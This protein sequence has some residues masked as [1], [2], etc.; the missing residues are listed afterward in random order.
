MAWTDELRGRVVGLDTAPLIYHVEEKVPYLAAVDPFF[1]ALTAGEF[2]VVTSVLTLSEAL[3]QPVRHN[4]TPLAAIYRSILLNTPG[5][6]ITPVSIQI[7]ERAA[8]IRAAHR[9]VRLPDAVQL[10]TALIGGADFFLT[11]D[12]ALPPLPG[13]KNAGGR[14][15]A[16]GKRLIAGSFAA[17]A[18]GCGG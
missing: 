1:A 17:A 10:A 4:D 8:A 7:A 11:N 15:F 6:I 5:L 14:G 3:V 18:N 13:L 2:R 12:I 16:G 9:R